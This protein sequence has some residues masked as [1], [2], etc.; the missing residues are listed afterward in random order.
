MAIY[1]HKISP[2]FICGYEKSRWRQ[3]LHQFP[4][5]VVVVVVVFV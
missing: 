3:G 5:I 4:E 2:N 1:V